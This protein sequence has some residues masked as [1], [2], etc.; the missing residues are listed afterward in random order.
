M[1]LI[2]L[3]RMAIVAIPLAFLLIFTVWLSGKSLMHLTMKIKG[4]YSIASTIVQQAVSSIRMVYAYGGEKKTVEE[5]CEA[6]H[7]IAKIGLRQGLV[8]GLTIGS[9]GVA[10]AI[11]SAMAYYGSTLVMHHHAQEGTVFAV[12]NSIVNGAL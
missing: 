12:G 5:F 2:L 4:E 7:G 1:A 11:W 9:K 8:K 6:L 10:F 3:W